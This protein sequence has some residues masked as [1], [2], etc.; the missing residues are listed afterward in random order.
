MA[1]GAGRKRFERDGAVIVAFPSCIWAQS[2]LFRI[3]VCQFKCVPV[4]KGDF[5][6]GTTMDVPSAFRGWVTSEAFLMKWDKVNDHNCPLRPTSTLTPHKTLHM[7][8]T[9]Y[10]YH[11]LFEAF[12]DTCPKPRTGLQPPSPIPPKH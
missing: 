12:C 8:Q 6:T 1:V 9:E 5:D 3:C 4:K 2:F 10:K 7:L 11:F